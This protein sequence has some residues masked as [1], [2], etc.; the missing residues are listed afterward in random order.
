MILLIFSH[1]NTVTHIHAQTTQADVRA[2]KHAF[3]R[4]GTLC[5]TSAQNKIV[6][7]ALRASGLKGIFNQF[8]LFKW[9]LAA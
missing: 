2:H 7:F 6:V 5:Y 9:T 4:E 3:L 1:A 8:T